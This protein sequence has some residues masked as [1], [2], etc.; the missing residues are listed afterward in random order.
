MN[1]PDTE[2]GRLE[3]FRQ[4]ALS[5]LHFIFDF[6]ERLRKRRGIKVREIAQLKR[7]LKLPIENESRHAAILQEVRKKVRK[8]EYKM[9]DSLVVEIVKWLFDDSERIQI[10]EARKGEGE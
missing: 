2:N 1:V 8:L 6:L 10:E 7:K 4:Q 3:H 9:P 5:D